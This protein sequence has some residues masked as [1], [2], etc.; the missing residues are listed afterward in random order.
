LHHQG[1]PAAF[2]PPVNDFWLYPI[3]EQT[4]RFLAFLDSLSGHEALHTSGVRSDDFW[5][6]ATLSKMFCGPA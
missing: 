2:Q 1:Y 3:D 5:L 4:D 6:R